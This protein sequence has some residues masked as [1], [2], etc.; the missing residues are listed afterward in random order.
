MTIESEVLEELKRR[1]A[2]IDRQLDIA[3]GKG[4]GL[5]EAMELMEKRDDLKKNETVIK[6]AKEKTLEKAREIIKKARKINEADIQKAVANKESVE[7]SYCGVWVLEE[8]VLGELEKLIKNPKKN[9][10]YLHHM[11]VLK[12]THTMSNVSANPWKRTGGSKH[13]D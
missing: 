13:V 7:W 5:D 11:S 4:E 10:R 6:L 12:P 1:E 8:E 2:E 3:S 9:S